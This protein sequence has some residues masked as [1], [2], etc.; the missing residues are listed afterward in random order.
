[1]TARDEEVEAGAAGH[2]AGR[3]RAA[4][5]VARLAGGVDD[6]EVGRRARLVGEDRQL[7]GALG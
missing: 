6:L 2:V 7:V 3:R 4:V 5:G 1:V